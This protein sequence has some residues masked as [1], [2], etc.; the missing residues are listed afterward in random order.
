MVIESQVLLLVEAGVGLHGSPDRCL[1]NR[2]GSLWLGDASRSARSALRRLSL[3]CRRFPLLEFGVAE[4][5]SLSGR[6]L[7]GRG[8]LS[9]E[10]VAI[11]HRRSGL[12]SRSKC[13]YGVTQCK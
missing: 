10:L 8:G 2:F 9:M 6:L 4:R 12:D 11:L 1:G 13:K 3:R 5:N 7:L